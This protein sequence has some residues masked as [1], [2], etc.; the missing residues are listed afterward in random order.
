MLTTPQPSLEPFF[1]EGIHI[2]LS[3]EHL[4]SLWGL[5]ITNTLVMTWVVTLLLVAAS[6]LIGR[7]LSLA[8]PSRVQAL[9]E[10]GIEGGISFADGVLEN[11][12]VSRSLFPLLAAIFLYIALSNLLE[13]I[14]GVGSIGFFSGSGADKEFIPLFR[15]A[16][17]DL[18]TTIALTLI[19]FVVIEVYGVRMLGVLKYFGK[20]FNFK[21]HTIAERFLNL[22]VGI[23]ELVSELGRLIS[24]S[25]RLYGN[26]F[27]GEV[28]IGVI[29]FFVPYLL[30]SPFLAFEMFVGVLQGGIFAL[31]TL[32]FVK[33]A[34]TD[35]HE[36]H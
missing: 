34:I 32:F 26:I 21:G 18:N 29:S 28:L 3:A 7:K 15:S 17:T 14:P 6:I 4:G 16:N 31:L 35:P 33:L 27:A 8:K 36:S 24:F 11:E 30:P 22:L 13:F 10:T 23:I 12:K 1:M 5:P 19:V 2:S 20:F 25:F 9:V